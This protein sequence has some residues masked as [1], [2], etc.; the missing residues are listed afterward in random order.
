MEISIAGK[1]TIDEH[2]RKAIVEENYAFWNSSHLFMMAHTMML[3]LHNDEKL[4]AHYEELAD[5]FLHK[6]HAILH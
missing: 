4:R 3:I 1:A 5:Y 2:F 6:S